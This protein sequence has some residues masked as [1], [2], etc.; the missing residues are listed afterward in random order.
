MDPKDTMSAYPPSSVA[1]PHLF[2]KVAILGICVERAI[3]VLRGM[4][5]LRILLPKNL[6]D[7]KN[8]IDGTIRCNK[9]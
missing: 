3:V 5:L 4:S 2:K 8:W 9:K 6:I 7:R 1:T